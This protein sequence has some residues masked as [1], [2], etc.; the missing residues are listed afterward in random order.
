MVSEL[1]LSSFFS[2]V[3]H[4]DYDWPGY[5][6][7]AYGSS[8]YAGWMPGS[9]MQFGPNPAD[10]LSLVTG[11]TSG[12]RSILEGMGRFMPQGY[13]GH[14]SQ[15]F[16]DS[17]MAFL[18][19]PPLPVPIFGYG[20]PAQAGNQPGAPA[21]PAPSSSI[22][23][24]T[25]KGD[26]SKADA[27]AAKKASDAEAIEKLKEKYES[28]DHG[29][30]DAEWK[31]I[32]AEAEKAA[33]GNPK[34][35]DRIMKA[36][37]SKKFTEPEIGEDKK[38]KGLTIEEQKQAWTRNFGKWHAEH[39]S[40]MKPAEAEQL[41]NDTA[42]GERVTYKL[43]QST[44]VA[45]GFK[46]FDIT[47][48][49]GTGSLKVGDSVY[50]KDK[51]WYRD[52]N[53]TNPIAETSAA[54]G[55]TAEITV[56]GQSDYIPLTPAGVHVHPD[57]KPTVLSRYTFAIPSGPKSQ[58]IARSIKPS[59]DGT[60]YIYY[61]P[62]DGKWFYK[63][64]D[65]EA[66]EIKGA[67]LID[68]RLYLDRGG[69]SFDVKRSDNVTGYMGD[70]R[71]AHD[72]YD[73]RVTRFND[74]DKGQ[75]TD[76]INAVRSY[77]EEEMAESGR[78]KLVYNYDADSNVLNI[79]CENDKCDAVWKAVGSESTEKDQTFN[80]ILL[81]LPKD[82]AITFNGQ[83]LST[84]GKPFNALKDALHRDV[85]REIKITDNVDMGYATYANA[86]D[87][88][89]AVFNELNRRIVAQREQTRNPTKIIF[90]GEIKLPKGKITAEGWERIKIKLAE[91]NKPAKIE[92]YGQGSKVKNI[93]GEIPSNTSYLAAKSAINSFYK[94]Y[95][96]KSVAEFA[97]KFQATMTNSKTDKNEKKDM[98]SKAEKYI[99]QYEQDIKELEAVQ[100]K[101]GDVEV[102]PDGRKAFLPI[103]AVILASKARLKA[104]RELKDK[105]GIS[106]DPSVL[107]AS[108]VEGL[109]VTEEID[110]SSAKNK[111]EVY[112]KLN[113]VV[114]AKVKGH[115]DTKRVTFDKAI[116]LPSWMTSS[117]FADAIGSLSISNYS[118]PVY[119]EKL[120][121][122]NR[123]G[124]GNVCRWYREFEYAEKPASDSPAQHANFDE[125]GK[126]E[127]PPTPP[128]VDDASKSAAATPPEPNSP[129]GK[130]SSDPVTPPSQDDATSFIQ[131]AD[132]TGGGL[133]E[134]ERALDSTRGQVL[135]AVKEKQLAA[136]EALKKLASIRQYGG[137]DVS[138]AEKDA[139]EKVAEYKKE[140][141]A[142]FS[143][144][145]KYRES[146]LYS[147]ASELD[148]IRKDHIHH[149]RKLEVMTTAPDQ[150]IPGSSERTIADAEYK[151]DFTML[152]TEDYIF[153]K[154]QT[155]KA[156]ARQGQ[157]SEQAK[158]DFNEFIGNYENLLKGL[159]NKFGAQDEIVRRHKTLLSGLKAF[160]RNPKTYD[161]VQLRGV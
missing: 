82:C 113:E 96:H 99:A 32:V 157:P 143:I 72:E 13:V 4:S 106:L 108:D 81:Q 10:S 155:Y 47:E 55:A 57:S 59:S 127:P 14:A 79:T 115:E 134:Q 103:R 118:V 139:E 152:Y 161:L 80:N 90:D 63:K 71:A 15:G 147:K 67:Q 138:A 30:P 158:S 140:A 141:T 66:P 100:A 153:G 56:G 95:S 20:I 142:L 120:M 69:D 121:F 26:P 45:N 17:V 22:N 128:A 52:A 89:D 73:S 37:P 75:R 23:A 91:A 24:S 150:F 58:E 148:L 112:A 86:Q 2:R 85:S 64:G 7:G 9:G 98:I 42:S 48:V 132:V 50:Y 33:D 76:R 114:A 44:P 124:K 111:E 160:Q 104:L 3:G 5:G 1:T 74:L 107:S 97:K 68:G 159:E 39:I 154:A 122:S 130:A 149:G 126:K 151:T 43:K 46:K 38:P 92:F 146:G 8:P 137:G 41:V 29:Y 18:N 135:S 129:S 101:Y 83:K 54:P 133:I 70:L 94:K 93:S 36:L 65:K 31:A 19:R 40:G 105:P 117:D 62:S 88:E 156:A 125:K 109:H 123:V 53:G 28:A 110:L 84:D 87:A 145:N 21:A 78:G 51:K 60:T 102:L 116:K 12:S 77:F 61:S 144:Q 25:P 35:F 6:L 49:N 136:H 119:F 27:D 131:G 16:G 11:P 34:K